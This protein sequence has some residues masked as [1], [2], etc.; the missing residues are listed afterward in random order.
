MHENL[1][2]NIA[3]EALHIDPSL[4]VI[5]HRLMGGMSNYTY[6]INCDGALYTFRIPG[7][8]ADQFVNRTHEQ[9]HITLEESLGLNNETV[10]FDPETGYK[11]AKYLK[12]TPLHEKNPL[13]YLKQASDVLHTIHESGIESPYPYAPFERLEKY[14]G[15][16]NEYDHTHDARYHAAKK[17]LTDHR[18]FLEETPLTFTHGDAQISNFLDTEDGLKL[19]DWEFTGMNDPFYDLACFG[20]NDFS[21]AESLLPVYLNKAPSKDEWNRL[22]LWRL[23]QTLQWH[24]VAL[25]KHYIGLSKDLNVDFYKVSNLYLDKADTMI[26]SLK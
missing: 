19:M 7:K 22:Y 12:G 14:E 4:I 18:S 5:D 24:N 1:I 26:A 8:N 10:Y 13:D 21:H 6:V 11:I 17:V 9:T 3:S 15:Y 16:L 2:K 25:Y 23:F 20:N